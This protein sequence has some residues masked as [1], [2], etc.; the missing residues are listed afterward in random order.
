MSARLISDEE[1]RDVLVAL[2]DDQSGEMSVKELADFVRRG[3]STDP[4]DIRG[5]KRSLL[6]F[7][8]YGENEIRRFVTMCEDIDATN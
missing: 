8:S 1:I 3:V 2:D 7:D 5:L 6:L 4:R